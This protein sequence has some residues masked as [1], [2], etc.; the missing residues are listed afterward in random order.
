M[1]TVPNS[2]RSN[3]GKELRHVPRSGQSP[4]R[5][6]CDRFATVAAGCLQTYWFQTGHAC[7]SVALCNINAL[8]SCIG[9]RAC[10]NQT[11]CAVFA[12]ILEPRTWS[13][14]SH[15]YDLW[16]FLEDGPTSSVT[17]GGPQS[18]FC[19]ENGLSLL[20]ILI[21]HGALYQLCRG[22]GSPSQ[23][24]GFLRVGAIHF[25]GVSGDTWAHRVLGVACFITKPKGKEQ[26][27]HWGAALSNSSRVSAGRNAG[28]LAEGERPKQTQPPMVGW[29][30]CVCVCV[31]FLGGGNLLQD[32]GPGVIAFLGCL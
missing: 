9:S 27:H 20:L 2:R 25:V 6:K 31:F 23:S 7:K 11:A 12:E 3:S 4:S 16:S 1:Q 19:K 5:A 32:R 26:N 29:R 21:K 30:F 14:V 28:L 22:G 24:L 17:K 18:T 13:Q 10:L 15:E 8:P